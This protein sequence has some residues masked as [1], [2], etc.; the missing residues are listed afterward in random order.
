MVRS[1]LIALETIGEDGF[2]RAMTKPLPEYCVCIGIFV[3]AVG[4]PLTS[5]DTGNMEVRG[6][7]DGRWRQGT[8]SNNVGE[9]TSAD[10]CVSEV[11]LHC[12]ELG[13]GA[14]FSIGELH[15]MPLHIF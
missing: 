10:C 7:E 14:V 6:R 5:K 15:S 9:K 1:Q 8:C 4:W 2:L 13:L 11:L 12:K 3:I